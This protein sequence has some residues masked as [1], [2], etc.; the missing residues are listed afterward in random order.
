MMLRG[1][2]VSAL[3]NAM[4][5]GA[6]SPAFAAI[7]LATVSAIGGSSISPLGRTVSGAPVLASEAC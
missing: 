7:A 1:G 6:S 4:A 3:S 5:K 2:N